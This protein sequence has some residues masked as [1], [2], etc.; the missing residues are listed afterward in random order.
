M[1]DV[2]PSPS[3]LPTNESTVYDFLREFGLPAGLL[4]NTATS[5]F[6][7]KNASFEVNLAGKCYVNF[8]YLVYYEPKIT[9]L[10]CYGVIAGLKGI[11]VRNYLLWFNVDAV[12][13]D[14]Q[15][16]DY[17]FFDVGLVTKKL[18]VEQFETVHSCRNNGLAD[19]ME[20][21]GEEGSYMANSSRSSIGLFVLT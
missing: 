17:I 18:K 5:F 11:Q 3:Y 10:I 4:P 2:T 12:K 14:L 7:Y 13:I 16:S 1:A 8:E 9:G 6:Y 20:L 21:S 15:P 19:I